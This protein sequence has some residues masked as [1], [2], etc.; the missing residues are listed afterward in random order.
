MNN[1]QK[2]SLELL[3]LVQQNNVFP[4][5][6]TIN[7]LTK[8]NLKKTNLAVTTDTISVEVLVHIILYSIRRPLGKIS[9]KLSVFL[10]IINELI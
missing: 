5:S 1:N 7:F 3:H 4:L 8:Q 2:H 9:L 6:K 10:I